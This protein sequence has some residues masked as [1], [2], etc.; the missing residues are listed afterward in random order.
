MLDRL[1]GMVDPYF[2]K[3]IPTD[4]SPLHRATNPHPGQ[5]FILISSCAWIEKEIVYKPVFTQLDIIL[6][7]NGYI[8]LT[9]PQMNAIVYHADGRRLVKMQS[10][11]KKAGQEYA[12]AGTVSKETI[13]MLARPMF[14]DTVYQMFYE[15]MWRKPNGEYLL[16][17]IDKKSN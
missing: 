5:R 14:S 7:K 3:P 4:G 10:N 8:A 16:N 12:A 2:G 6:G 13:D 17:E 15:N 9:T 1:L 11:Y